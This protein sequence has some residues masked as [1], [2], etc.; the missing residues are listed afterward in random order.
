[1]K[2]WRQASQDANEKPVL[3]LNEKK[4]LE[5]LRAQDQL[6]IRRPKQE[7][8]CKEKVLVGGGCAADRL[9]KYA[10]L[11]GEDRGDCPRLTSPRSL[12]RS[13]LRVWP[14]VHLPISSPGGPSADRRTDSSA[15]SGLNVSPH[16]CLWDLTGPLPCHQRLESQGRGL[17]WR[18]ASGSNHRDGSAG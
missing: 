12:C 13:W 7:L 18:G 1:M 10:G 11:W 15:E 6:E 4:D 5:R 2:R 14:R 9:K 8:R 16:D 3:N 17:G